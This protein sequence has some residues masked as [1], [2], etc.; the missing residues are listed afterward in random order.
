[1]QVVGGSVS[2]DKYSTSPTKNSRAEIIEADFRPVML[3]ASTDDFEIY[4]ED[5]PIDE[6][7]IQSQ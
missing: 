5:E 6:S 1:M 2:F 3:E 7:Q 4:Y